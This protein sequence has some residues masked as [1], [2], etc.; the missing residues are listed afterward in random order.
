ME[1]S[2]RLVPCVSVCSGCGSVDFGADGGSAC[3]YV[4]V[5]L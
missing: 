1:D 2:N 5:S 3:C 4:S